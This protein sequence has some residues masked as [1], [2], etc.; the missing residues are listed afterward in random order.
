MRVFVNTA[1]FAVVSLMLGAALSRT[2]TSQEATA[3]AEVRH[4]GFTFSTGTCEQGQEFCAV[5]RPK[6]WTPQEIALVQSAL[7]EIGAARLGRQILQRAQQN[8]FRTLR[9]Y[10]QAAEPNTAGRYFADSTIVAV[11][12]ADDQHAVRSI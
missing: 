6:P 2:V 7:D 9:R 8:G 1:S 12:H 11:T 3:R 4:E 10:T 5:T